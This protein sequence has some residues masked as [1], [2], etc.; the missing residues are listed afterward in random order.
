MVNFSPQCIVYRLICR[1][2]QNPL[3][4]YY[5]ED[6]FQSLDDVSFYIQSNYDEN[7]IYYVQVIEGFCASVNK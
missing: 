6:D 3:L 2:L 4:D 1:S 5:V 7:F